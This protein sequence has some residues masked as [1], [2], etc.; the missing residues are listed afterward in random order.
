MTSRTDKTI[1]YG[2]LC[3]IFF[4]PLLNAIAYAGLLVAII[5][6]LC[7]IKR[8]KIVLDDTFKF[9]ILSFA[10]AVLL[11]VIFSHNKPQSWGGYLL[12]TFYL[13]TFILMIQIHRIREKVL[14]TAVISLLLISVFGIIQ[15]LTKLQFHIK[16]SWFS[17]SVYTGPS[18]IGA[19]FDNPNRFAAYLVP[20]ILMTFV[21]FVSKTSVRKRILSG[22]SLATGITCLILTRSL[23]GT[24]VVVFL[25]PIILIIR[26][27][28]IGLCILLGMFVFTWLI[29]GYILTFSSNSSR[30]I[31]IH[32]WETIVPKVIKSFPLFGYGLATSEDITDKYGEG[33]KTVHPDLHNLYLN[34]LCE[35]GFL[36]FISFLWIIGLFLRTVIPKVRS[37]YEVFACTF[38]VLGILL[39]GMSQTILNYF[40]LGLILWT[41]TGLSLAKKRS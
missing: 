11:S 6:W 27:W 21:L 38:G 4:L 1:E 19:T 17:F 12:F 18:G 34:F 31:R 28:K 39:H 5:C 40:Q 13:L 9:A 24:L 20:I 22:I 10:A 2:I 37:D 25:I 33:K 35:I 30:N 41:L 32:S 14:W 3:F 7:K 29:K 15:H 23:A 26:N 8:D 16:T 36:G